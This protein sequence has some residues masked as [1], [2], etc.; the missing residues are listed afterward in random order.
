[1]SFFRLRLFILCSMVASAF[2]SSASAQDTGF[3]TEAQAARGKALY[4][5]NCTACHGGTLDGGESAPGLS[6][7][8]FAGKWGKLPLSLLFGY[9]NTKM[10][11]GAPGS[12]GAQANADITAFILSYN[13]APAGAKELPPDAQALSGMKLTP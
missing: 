1:M 7:E 13:K 12:L 3:Y 10:P 6:G 4:F 5:D 9:I 11:L 8:Y 2:G